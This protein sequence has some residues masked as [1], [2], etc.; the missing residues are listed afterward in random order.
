M[1]ASS[2]SKATYINQDS[3]DKALDKNFCI[4]LYCD[5]PSI[6]CGLVEPDYELFRNSRTD[7]EDI[8]KSIGN[9][10]DYL[11]SSG[12]TTTWEIQENAMI[13]LFSKIRAYNENDNLSH[14]IIA[15][16]YWMENSG[17]G[18]IRHPKLDCGAGLISEGVPMPLLFVAYPPTRFTID[19]SPGRIYARALLAVASFSIKR[20]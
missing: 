1:S 20:M 9:G 2:T 17:L 12:T 7:I 18:V 4:K 8:V 15:E 10:I 14:I 11:G 6:L 13:E 5:I 3:I 19:Q 16:V